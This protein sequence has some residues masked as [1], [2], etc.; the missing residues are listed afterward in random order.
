MHIFYLHPSCRWLMVRPLCC[1]WV[2]RSSIWILLF[3]LCAVCG[4]LLVLQGKTHLFDFVYEGGFEFGTHFVNDDHV[5]LVCVWFCHHHALV[6]RSIHSFVEHFCLLLF[7]LLSL[8][9]L[10]CVPL[11]FE[12]LLVLLWLLLLRLDDVAIVIV[13]LFI[14]WGCVLPVFIHFVDYQIVWIC[15]FVEGSR[16]GVV[17]LLANYCGLHALV[18]WHLGPS[19]LFPSLMLFIL[20]SSSYYFC[21]WC[22][23]IFER[24]HSCPF[25]KQLQHLVVL[26]SLLLVSNYSNCDWLRIIGELGAFI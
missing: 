6:L 4:F 18:S 14:N 23:S 7:V 15:I 21:C 10:H 9:L 3:V 17:G 1:I 2:P 16:N 24:I 5:D 13:A 11:L 19:Q 25:H 12:L 8:L 26:A 22:A 20:P